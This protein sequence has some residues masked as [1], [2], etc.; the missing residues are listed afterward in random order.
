[1]AL[2]LMS[3]LHDKP[4]SATADELATISAFNERLEAEG[5]R[6]FAGGPASSKHRNRRVE[7]RPFLDA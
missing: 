1:M 3:V 6:V 4:N 7:L 2:Y 5:H